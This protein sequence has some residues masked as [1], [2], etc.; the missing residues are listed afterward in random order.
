MGLDGVVPVGVLT[1]KN[2]LKLFDYCKKNGHAIP[3]SNLVNKHMN[4]VQ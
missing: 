1:G 4:N 3:G 2:V